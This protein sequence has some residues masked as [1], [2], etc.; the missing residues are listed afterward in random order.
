MTTTGDDCYFFY[1][2][3]C[4]KGKTCSYRHCAHALG[5]ETICTLWTKTGKCL[6]E[7]CPY[8][9]MDIKKVRNE[10]DCYW[11]SQ[12]TG[13]RK[14]HCVFRHRR[15]DHNQVIASLTT[16]AAGSDAVKSTS[17]PTIRISPSNGV[18]T[19]TSKHVWVNPKLQSTNG[20]N[21]QQHLKPILPSI[22]F[23]LSSNE[24][25]DDDDVESSTLGGSHNVQPVVIRSATTID[26]QRRRPIQHRYADDTIRSNGI[27][28]RL[29]LTKRKFD[30]EQEQ[31][32]A[33][34]ASRYDNDVGSGDDQETT[35]RDLIM[36]TTTKRRAIDDGKRAPIKLRKTWKQHQTGAGRKDMNGASESNRLMLFDE[37]LAI[38][39]KAAGIDL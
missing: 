26:E 10:T 6:K 25:D 37:E 23:G 7:N 15:P 38:N 24:D 22:D 30:D 5:N 9:H 20:N 13:C 33:E 2:S 12:P 4:T 3:T 21:Q 39:L 27:D 16:A 34:L 31:I 1:Y 35:I 36:Q 18:N 8:R 28:L 19:A 11:E 14:P 29:K 17:S 32:F